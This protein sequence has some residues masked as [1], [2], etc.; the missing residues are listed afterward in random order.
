MIHSGW[1]SAGQ[2]GSTERI[3]C[4]DEDDDDDDNS[5]IAYY[6]YLNITAHV[7]TVI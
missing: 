2:G 7:I 4:D 5:F 6:S 3:S 1:N